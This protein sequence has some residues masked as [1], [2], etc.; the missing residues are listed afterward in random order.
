MHWEV[1]HKNVSH[2]IEVSRDITK[3]KKEEIKLAES[4]QLFRNLVEKST[5]PIFILKG[6]EMLLEVMTQ[7][8]LTIFNITVGSLGKPLLQVLPEFKGQPFI[9]WLMYVYENGVNHYG[10]FSKGR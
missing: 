5:S 3:Q 1:E 10:K 8:V 6:K 9:E 2:I 7:P 4:E